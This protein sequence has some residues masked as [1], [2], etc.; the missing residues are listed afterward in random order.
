[1]LLT[2]KWLRA[3]YWGTKCV[4]CLYIDKFAPFHNQ[5]SVFHK[6]LVKFLETI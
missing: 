5:M 4:T 3:V 2:C 1:M 6:I